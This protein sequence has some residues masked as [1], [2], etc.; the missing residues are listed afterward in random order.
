MCPKGAYF[1]QAEQALEENPFFS[2]HH[3]DSELVTEKSWN[4]FEVL[5]FHISH[6]ILYVLTSM[7]D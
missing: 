1:L 3:A 7:K 4:I 2:R 6:C 5:L